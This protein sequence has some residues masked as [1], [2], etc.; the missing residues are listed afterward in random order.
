MPVIEALIAVAGMLALS[1]L[2]L[3]RCRQMEA[4]WTNERKELL[5]RIQHPEVRQIKPVHS[6]PIEPPKDAAEL[7]MVGMEVPN[8]Y[9]VGGEDANGAG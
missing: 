4:D 6:E 5:D 7:A 9:D 2:N 1:I 3:R 8:G